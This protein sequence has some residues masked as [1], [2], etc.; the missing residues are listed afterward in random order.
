MTANVTSD[1]GSLYAFWSTCRGACHVLWKSTLL[2]SGIDSFNG[3]PAVADG[4]VYVAWADDSP[5]GI[6]AFPAGPHCPGGC[7]PLWTGTAGNYELRGT[8]VADGELWVSGG[9]T[10]GPGTVYAFGVS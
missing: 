4:V 6:A 8:T 7:P 9:P 3:S 1:D 10:G 2:A 5:V